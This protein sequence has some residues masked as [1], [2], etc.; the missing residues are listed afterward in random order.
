MFCNGR[1]CK[2]VQNTKSWHDRLML[3]GWSDPLRSH[4]IWQ[5][6]SSSPQWLHLLWVG[7][8]VAGKLWSIPKFYQTTSSRKL[9]HW[10]KPVWIESGSCMPPF[11]VLCAHTLQ[12]S[13]PPTWP[14]SLIPVKPANSHNVPSTHKPLITQHAKDKTGAAVAHVWQ[15]CHHK[16]DNCS[17]NFAQFG[18]KW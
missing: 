10:G 4:W 6:W 1:S 9:Q 13:H 17:Y 11:F 14:Q 7:P 18:W 2:S 3:S 15:L 16:I 8:K 5:V 12:Q